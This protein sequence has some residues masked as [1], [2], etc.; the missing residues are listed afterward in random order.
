MKYISVITLLI[1]ITGMF[2]CE[3]C[4]TNP[5]Q[6]NRT[7]IEGEWIDMSDEIIGSSV[8]FLDTIEEL[9][10]VGGG[11]NA[12]I[13]DGENLTKIKDFEGYI[14]DI[15]KFKDK[16]YFV[17]FRCI[18]NNIYYQN[19]LLEWD[20]EG[21][22]NLFEINGLGEINTL[23]SNNDYLFVGGYFDSINNISAKNIVKFDGE[24]W[25]SFGYPDIAMVAYISEFNNVY[26]ISNNLSSNNFYYY[27][28]NSW[29]PINLISGITDIE[30][31]KAGI[32]I[33]ENNTT[34][35]WDGYNLNIYQLDTFSNIPAEEILNY[36]DSL[37]FFNR[38]KIDSLF[39]YWNTKEW[40]YFHRPPNYYKAI[41]EAVIY[42]NDLYINS[43]N[44][45]KFSFK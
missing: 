5:T 43:K 2:S 39:Y 45:K 24:N 34:E 40:K 7:F 11:A 22:T 19:I 14:Y 44:L 31:T 33:A 41:T 42:K 4:K 15:T 29:K 27:R 21:V 13:W 12:Y 16:I 26:F 9:L 36:N 3:K 17:V 1:L 37:F 6:D 23:Y 10:Y 38:P 35:I 28:N 30:K 8:F 25:S 18:Y 32:L 20:N